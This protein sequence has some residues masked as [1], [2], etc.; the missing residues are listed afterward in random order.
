MFA[1]QGQFWRVDEKANLEVVVQRDNILMAARHT[2]QDCDLIADL[3][4]G[5][6]LHR[7][8]QLRVAPVRDN[9]MVTYHELSTLHELLVD[10]LTSIILPSFDMDSFLH[11]CI[12]ST[13]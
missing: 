2:F 10:H 12:R 11:D 5:Q 6:I 1:G 9:N 4:Q 3:G 7:N 13:A 8:S